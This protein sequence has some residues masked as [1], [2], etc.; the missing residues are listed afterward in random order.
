MRIFSTILLVVLIAGVAS[1]PGCSG[2]K[3]PLGTLHFTAMSSGKTGIR[4]NNRLFESDSVNVYENEYMYN[5]SGVGIGDF[6][7]DGLADVFFAGSMVSSRLYL[8]RGDFLFDDITE[9]AGVQ[10]AQWC[11]GVSVVDINADGYLDIYVSSSHAADGEKRKNLL[12][13]NNGFAPSREGRGEVTFTEMAEAYGL[14]D[15][16]CA[17]QAAFFDYDKDGDLDMYLLNH[18][19]FYADANSVVPIDTTGDSPAADRLYRNE[20]IPAGGQHPVFRD[21]S[22]EA[23]IKEDGYGLGIVITDANGDNWPD[24]YVAND[25]LGSDRFWLNN[26]NG[27]FS[28]IASTSLKHQSYNSMG[29]DAADI[30]NDGLPD[31]AVLD[32][33]PETNERKKMMFNA[34]SQEKFDMALRLGYD[35]AFVR[36]MLQLNNGVRTKENRT[37]PYYSEVGQAAGISET[38]WSW[39]VLM[40]DFD[41]DGWKDMYITNGLAK[42][43]TNNDYAAFRSE[44]SAAG[45]NFSGS[46]GRGKMDKETI[47]VLRKHLDEYGSVKVANYFYRNKGNLTF[48]NSTADAGLD[49]PSVSN[50]AAYADLDNDGDLD[51]VVN[52]MNQEAFV[53]RNNLRAS[54]KDTTQNFLSV[55]LKGEVSNPFGLGSKLYLY[56]GGKQ[57]LVEQS[58]VRGFSSSIDYKLHF[59]I[60]NAN[61]IDSIK[62][63]WP[64]DKMQVIT[65]V[66][67]NRLL[68][69]NQSEATQTETTQTVVNPAPLFAEETVASGLFFQH[70]ENPFFDFGNRRPL[71]QKYSQLGP[72]IAV[73]DMNGD[74]REDVFVGGAANQSGKLFFQQANGTFREKNLVD[75]QKPEED[76][77]AYLFDADGDKDL[78]LLITGG[79]QE[80]GTALFNK[81]RF[82]RNRGNGDFEFLPDVLPANITDITKEAAIADFD[83]DGDLDIFLGGRLSPFNYPKSPRSYVLQNNGGVFTDIT[84]NVCPELEFAGLITGALFSDFNGDKLPDLVLCGEWMPVRFFQNNGGT[85]SEVT[86]TTGLQEFNGQWRSLQ[87]ADLDDD[88]DTDYIV[89]NLGLNTKFNIS[90]EKPMKL[91]AGDFD[92]NQSFDLIAAYFMKGAKGVYDLF[93]SPD[94][95]MLADQLPSVKKKYLLSADYSKENMKGLLSNLNTKNMLVKTCEITA[96]VWMENKGRGKFVQHN[97]PF[98]AQLAPVNSIIARDLDGDGVTDLLLAGNEYSTEYSTGRYDAGYGTVLKGT[99]KGIFMVLPPVRSGFVVDGDVRGMGVLTLK[100]REAVLV[101]INNNKLKFFVSTNAK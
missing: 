83:S 6:N 71:P 38:D 95:A 93:P 45:Y 55:Q 7:R 92:G 74:G 26:G 14:A 86:P 10:T 47:S 64:D 40:A 52:N 79:S 46:G 84:K 60:G 73:G 72:C 11:T 36:N 39:S 98:A 101:A 91:Y 33:M 27:T 23:G 85:F 89:G 31:L 99:G 51:L 2:Q 17:T 88:G 3:K 70:T 63:I 58:P 41:N 80:F 100:N 29:V 32:M 9:K 97:L 43:V 77:G 12:F 87:A 76:L 61:L 30:N 67:S 13:V 75:G 34:A 35:P 49:E 19:L 57:Q 66:S 48:D 16:G 68:V 25:Y 56:S 54:A 65:N 42:D 28:N 81:P 37:E 59:G 21:I 20:G 90:P 82:Y 69:L 4:F 50:G 18:R 8:N 78:D 94:R 22:K 62:V 44:Q 1:L 5:G 96:S 24:I 15:S 53:W